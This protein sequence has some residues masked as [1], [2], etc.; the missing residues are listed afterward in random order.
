MQRNNFEKG[1]TLQQFEMMCVFC[2]CPP[3]FLIHSREFHSLFI[4]SN[5]LESQSS[6]NEQQSQLKEEEGKP[7]VARFEMTLGSPVSHSPRRFWG[8]LFKFCNR[9]FQF[10]WEWPNC[11]VIEVNTSTSNHFLCSCFQ[12]Q[13]VQ[14]TK[15]KR[16]EESISQKTY[17]YILGQLVKRSHGNFRWQL[18]CNY[19]LKVKPCKIVFGHI[20]DP[21]YIRKTFQNSFGEWRKH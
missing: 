16:G 13:K 21:R 7:L 1:Q 18:V 17:W 20:T 19:F 9:V 12:T 8:T 15:E 2:Y 11:F 4:F 10:D 3:V 14:G 5:K 6:D